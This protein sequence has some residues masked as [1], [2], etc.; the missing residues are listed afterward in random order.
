M[1]KDY[2]DRLRMVKA[3]R[4]RLVGRGL[5]VD[6]GKR[7]NG[8]IVYVLSEMAKTLPREILEKMF[9]DADSAH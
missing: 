1:S 2:D 8:E 4:E 7:R 5:V 3:A 6:S 9:E